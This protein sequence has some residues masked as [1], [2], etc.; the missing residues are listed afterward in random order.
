MK[1]LSFLEAHRLAHG[2]LNLMNIWVSQAGKIM[3][4]VYP[5]SGFVST[6]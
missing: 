4:G 6:T 5:V 1:A 2:K 3:I